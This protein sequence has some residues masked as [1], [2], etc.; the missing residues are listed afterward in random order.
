VNAAHDLVL[1]RASSKNLRRGGRRRRR[2]PSSRCRPRGRGAQVREIQRERLGLRRQDPRGR[3]GRRRPR[4]R[5]SRR[6]EQ[7][8]AGLFRPRF[9]NRLFCQLRQLRAPSHGMPSG[10]TPLQPPICYT[11]LLLLPARLCVVCRYSRAQ[12]FGKAPSCL[13]AATYVLRAPKSTAI[14]RALLFA[15]RL[16][17][18]RY[19]RVI[20]MSAWPTSSAI[21]S[22]SAPP[23]RARVM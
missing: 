11:L 3:C 8:G 1:G 15:L 10:L 9:S 13:K 22:S 17:R 5:A 23:A 6:V 7:T 21:A 14:R 4:N 20:R 18:S 16:D 2:E 19:R 12:F